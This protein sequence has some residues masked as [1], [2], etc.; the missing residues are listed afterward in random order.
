M[1]QHCANAQTV[2]EWLA[3]QPSVVHVNYPGLPHYPQHAL[4][5]R[6]FGGRGFGGM[7]SFD[8]RDAGQPEVFRFM[9]ALEL[10][11]PGTTLG[12]VYSLTLY[13]AHS[14]HRQLTAEVRASIGIS[15]GL[16]RLSVGIE[17]PEDI[18]ADLAQAL[19]SIHRAA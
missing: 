1:R 13:P 16:V 4:A 10:V 8:L 3:D 17:D 11:L 15:D 12:D 2:A 18:I 19:K 7:I 9:E 6:L 14:S 5:R